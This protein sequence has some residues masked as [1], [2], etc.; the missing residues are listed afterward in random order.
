MRLP[1]LAR[2]PEAQYENR[3]ALNLIAHLIK[4][5]QKA[6]NVARRELVKLLTDAWVLNEASRRGGE[7]LHG[8]RGRRFVARSQEGMETL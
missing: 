4:A 6:A 5:D 3:L 8:P 2:M 1:A 7:R